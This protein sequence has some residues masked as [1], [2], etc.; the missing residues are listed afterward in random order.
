MCFHVQTPVREELASI[1]D[2]DYA[3][4]GEYDA[5]YHLSGFDHPLLPVITQESPIVIQGFQWGLIPDWVQS[6]KK[7][8]ELQNFTLNATCENLFEKPSFR[9]SAKNKRCLVLVKGFF[10]NRHE[11][12]FKYPYFVYP[13]ERNCFPMGGLYS[14][15][16]NRETGEIVHTCTII[17]TPANPLMEK[18]HNTKKRM[19]LIF[20]EEQAKKWLQP[21][22]SKE[23]MT[24]I[25]VP[26]GESQLKSHTISR[27]INQFKQRNTNTEEVSAPV[28]YPELA[29]LDC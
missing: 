29:L 12:K 7:A 14:E 3:I 26:F 4:I 2:Q 20:R 25:M 13:S 15:W 11:G 22:L 9:N 21:G 27:M 23:E 5:A 24:E 18:I 8:R 1:F 10:E 28:I 6:Q 17:T 16:A 19:P